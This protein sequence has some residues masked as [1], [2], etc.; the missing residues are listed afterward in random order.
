MA[1]ELIN[2]PKERAEHVMLIDLGRNDIGRVAKYGSVRVPD[3]MVIE[4]Y[5]HVMHIV[6]SVQGEVR[7]GLDMFDV[8]R[9]TF[10]MGTLTG[11]PKVRTMELIEEFEGERRHV[12]GGCAGYFSFNGSMDTCITIRTIVMVGDRCYLQAAGGVVY[13]SVAALEFKETNNKLRACLVAIDR[14][15]QNM[16]AQ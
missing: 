15:E 4:K 7:D 16:G 8:L 6:S 5:S 11:A 14:A 3:L 10:P 12:Y 9:A 1:H 13:D 2:D